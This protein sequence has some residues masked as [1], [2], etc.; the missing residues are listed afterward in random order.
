MQIDCSDFLVNLCVVL[1]QIGQ[2]DLC[3]DPSL[4]REGGSFS[5]QIQVANNKTDAEAGTAQA[6]FNGQINE[7][8]T[9]FTNQLLNP[10]R[11]ETSNM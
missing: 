2:L 7:V 1:L 8:G 11:M 4:A 3:R 5:N 9:V 6:L 10:V